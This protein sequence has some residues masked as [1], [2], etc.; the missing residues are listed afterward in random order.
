MASLAL[1]LPCVPGGAEKLRHLAEECSGPRRTEFADFH[2]R[3]GLTAERWYLQQTPQGALFLLTL[4]GDPGGA[5]RK[6]A[7]S[8]HPFD[9]WFKEQAQAV[10]GVDFNQPLPAPPPALVFEG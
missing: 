2:R 10:H 7:A 9:Q 1:A 6:L 4:E 8:T 3:V 5:I